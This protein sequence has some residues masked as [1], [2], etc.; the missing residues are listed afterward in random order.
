M[1]RFTIRDV[2]WLMV[3][4]SMAGAWWADRTAIKLAYLDCDDRLRRLA[5]YFDSRPDQDGRM[6][7]EGV[8]YIVPP[9]GGKPILVWKHPWVRKSQLGH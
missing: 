7:Q 6:S 4:V 8:T 1:F 2:L 3:V 5:D 9:N